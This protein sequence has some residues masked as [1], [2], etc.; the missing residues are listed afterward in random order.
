MKKFQPR[1][2]FTVQAYRFALDP[3]T[4]DHA[5]GKSEV[6]AGELLLEM[7]TRAPEEPCVLA[8]FRS[9]QGAAPCARAGRRRQRERSRSGRRCRSRSSRATSA[10]RSGSRPWRGRLS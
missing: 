8:I 4:V 1:P 2:G 5:R 9:V 3:I 6:Q 7:F 10:R